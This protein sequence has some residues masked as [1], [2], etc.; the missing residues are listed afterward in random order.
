MQERVKAESNEVGYLYIATTGIYSLQGIYKFGVTRDIDR[1]RKELSRSTAAAEEFFITYFVR[2]ATVPEAKKLESSV[3]KALKEEGAQIRPR[4]EFY[5]VGNFLGL[6]GCI[7]HSAKVLGIKIVANTRAHPHDIIKSDEN[8]VLLEENLSSIDP[9][10]RSFYLRG[11]Q[12]L[13]GLFM[14][15][16]GKYGGDA[17][18][19]GIYGR[20]AGDIVGAPPSGN[21]IEIVQNAVAT[22]RGREAH[23]AFL[24][25]VR[26]CQEDDRANQ[27][28]GEADDSC[29]WSDWREFIHPDPNW[30]SDP[31]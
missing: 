10:Y 29:D 16:G 9:I 7:V 20:L 11:A 23:E 14:L 22:V 6:V 27:F 4:R 19:S 8:T 31:P 13:A 24:E 5:R 25:E 26:Q 21:L 17:L 30:P 12:D 3:K 2:C 18:A 28:F 1:R 15:V